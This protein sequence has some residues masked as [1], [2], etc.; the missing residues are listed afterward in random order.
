MGRWDVHEYD[1][2]GLEQIDVPAKLMRDLKVE[3]GDMFKW[4]K[5]D[6]NSFKATIVRKN[7][8]SLLQKDQSVSERNKE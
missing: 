6:D 5:I 1:Q 2:E 7:S 3:C 8:Y 4:E